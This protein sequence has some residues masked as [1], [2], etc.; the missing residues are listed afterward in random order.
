M[1]ILSLLFEFLDGV[2]VTKRIAYSLL[3]ITSLYKTL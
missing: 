3:I 2:G 1:K